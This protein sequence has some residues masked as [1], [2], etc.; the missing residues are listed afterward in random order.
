MLLGTV[1]SLSFAFCQFS[2]SKDD[3]LQ[4]WG[5]IRM[6][7]NSLFSQMSFSPIS[8]LSPQ[9]IFNK[10]CVGEKN[11]IKSNFKMTRRNG[12]AFL[13]GFAMILSVL[14]VRAVSVH[15]GGI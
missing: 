14:Q 6:K 11:P 15:Y 9:S 7:E 3:R 2:H 8:P 10:G 13:P 4:V 5:G 1:T 12:L